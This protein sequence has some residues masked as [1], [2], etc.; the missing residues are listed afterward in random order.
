MFWAEGAS[1]L[2]CLQKSAPRI[3]V[4]GRARMPINSYLCLA[5]RWAWILDWNPLDMRLLVVSSLTNGHVL[6]FAK[7]KIGLPVIQDSISHWSGE[8]ILSE[9]NLKKSE[10]LFIAGEPP[11]PSF[12]TAGRRQSFNDP[13]GQVML[14][15]LR[16]IDE[17]KPPFFIMENVRGILSASLAH[18]PLSKR[19][20][21]NIGHGEVMA[22]LNS[23]FS[24]MGYTVTAELVN[25]A[26]YGTP[27][28]R[29]RVVF[30]GSRDGFQV[31]MPIGGNSVERNLFQQK[32]RSLRDAIEDL[33]EASPEFTPFSQARVKYLKLLKE[34]QNWRDLPL[35]LQ[36]EALGGA[37]RS[38]GG[39][40]GFFRRLSFDEP[41]PTVPTSPV[42]KSTCLCHPIELRPLSI[43]E[44]AR[45][46]QF[47]DSWNL[48]DR[49][50]KNTG[51]R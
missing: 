32:W 10:L 17:L 20:T 35:Q 14:D 30:L 29:E 3:R 43:K 39:R 48:Q 44:Y 42:Q 9:F 16:I 25:A 37:F 24:E 12:S 5:V 11:C 45:I 51:N 46:Q 18:V 13:R 2:L 31:T 8:K 19:K 1:P 49:R 33:C 27:Q 34:G 4:Q 26:N 15:F 40:V 28:K 41:S 23:R 21:R 7:N 22:F 47:P 50:L 36:A 6:P 38:T